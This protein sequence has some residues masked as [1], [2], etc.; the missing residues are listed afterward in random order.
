MPTKA[1]KRP[2]Y[3]PNLRFGRSTPEVWI[4]EQRPLDA[5][6][7]RGLRI[8]YGFK[9]H[10]VAYHS[11]GLDKAMVSAF[12]QAA[13]PARAERFQTIGFEDFRARL[14]RGLRF[15][16]RRACVRQLAEIGTSVDVEA[17][18]R[19]VR[20]REIAEAARQYP[21]AA[22]ESAGKIADDIAA[23]GEW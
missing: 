2:P 14:E 15:M 16:V 1:K 7:L 19:L 3:R 17:L 21:E 20:E 4:P 10:L 9:T 13:T 18:A 5:W 12:E 6:L 23:V 22:H 11:G 8:R